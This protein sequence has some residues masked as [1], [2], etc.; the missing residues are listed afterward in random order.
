MSRGQVRS[1]NSNVRS[2]TIVEWSESA[3]LVQVCVHFRKEPTVSMSEESISSI[4]GQ[5]GTKFIGQ[6]LYYYPKLTSTM[7]IA[8]KKAR[9]GAAEG[10]VVIAD[11]Q[12]AGRG[13]LGRTWLSP[14]GNLAMSIILKPT[15]DKLTQLVMI[16]SLAVVRVIK[17][18]TDIEAEIKWPNDVLI[19]GKKVCGILIENE[20][21]QDHV[22][23]AVVGIGIN[24]SL[25]PPA[26][27]EISDSAT[28]LAYEF[29]KEVDKFELVAMLF[30]EFEQLYLE[31]K[32]GVPIHQEWQKHLGTLG[33]LVQV[34]AGE[35][36]E[37]GQA[38]T[39]NEHGDLI[40]RNYDGSST[41]ITIGD[42]TVIKD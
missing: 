10:S 21:Q 19:R 32:S 25:D 17:R 6:N 23:F 34:K 16:A 37:K 18:L 12:T 26:M 2:G 1:G 9:E 36:I 41:T 3:A 28:S 27:P 24:L 4:Q 30:S 8:K 13:R 33:K 31:A 39:V 11:E 15:I 22:L 29:D 35:T 38:E 20:V 5:L 42:V 14:K 40:L 7:T